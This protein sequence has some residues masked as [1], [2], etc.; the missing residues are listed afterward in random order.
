MDFY[1]KLKKL[2]DETLHIMIVPHSGE[3]IRQLKFKKIILHLFACFIVTICISLIFLIYSNIHLN[4]QL[5]RKSKNLSK[6]QKINTQQ[7]LEIS[8]LK[9]KTNEVSEKLS[10]LN[11]LE[12]QIRDLVG[13]KNM[14]KT[15]VSKPISRSATRSNFSKASI[16][17][18]PSDEEMDAQLKILASEMDDE[19]KVLNDLIGDVTTQLKILDAKPNKKPT[20]GKITSK[21]GYRINPITHRRQFH[22]GL[23]IANKQ[24]TN[25]IAAGT[26]IVTFSG[27][28]SGYGKSIIISHGYG[29]RSVYAHNKDNLVKVGQKVNKGDIIAKMGSTGRS[30]GPHVHF[31][32][33]YKGNKIDPQKFLNK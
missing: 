17:A 4:Q 15:S 28:K 13:L 27:R 3:S 1:K 14:N 9:N 5:D 8:E 23:D 19:T 24:G 26:G 16:G 25:I 18:T 12:F 30:T 29:Y 7:T 20:S 22:E 11:E 33:H 2:A 32:V 21:F 31:E 10:I 6:L